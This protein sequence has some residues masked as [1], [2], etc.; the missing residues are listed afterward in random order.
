MKENKLYP[1]AI[2]GS[3]LSKCNDLYAKTPRELR[4][5]MKTEIDKMRKKMAEDSMKYLL[6]TV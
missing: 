6:N 1:E 2:K 4:P 3:W 5:Q